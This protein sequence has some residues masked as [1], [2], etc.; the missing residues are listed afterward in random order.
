MVYSPVRKRYS[1]LNVETT[2]VDLNS[3]PAVAFYVTIRSRDGSPLYGL[4]AS[5]FM[6]TEDGV[7]ITKLH[8]DYL[9]RFLPSVSIS[10]CVDRSKENEPYHGDIPWVAEFILQ[11]MRKNDSIKVLNFNKEYWVGNKFDWSRRRTLKALRVREYGGGKNIGKALYNAVGDLVPRLNRRSVIFITDGS[12]HTDSFQTYTP[13]NIIRFAKSHY[14]PIYIVSFKEP[15]EQIR[16]IA[17]ETGGAVIR[18][19]HSDRLRSLYSEIKN[20]EEYR[21]VLVYST[22]KLHSFRGWWSD[23]KIEVNHKGQKGVEQGGYFVP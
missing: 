6:I 9:K 14:I 15:H 23:V 11:K 13:A 16:S 7:P 20:S 8:T 19:G 10:L 1:N 18:P 5:N 21:Y 22:F 4:D 2:S 12:V 3:Y 17:V